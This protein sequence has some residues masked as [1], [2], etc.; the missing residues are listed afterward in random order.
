MALAQFRHAL[1]QFLVFSETAALG[2]GLTVQQHQALLAIKAHR[3]AG[4]MRVG[5]LATYLLLKPHS[6]AGLVNRL[7]RAGLVR[8]QVPASD[9]RRVQL[10]LTAKA[11]RLLLRLS[12]AHLRE[13]RQFAPQLARLLRQLADGRS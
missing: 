3:P 1:R 6:A 8:R 7:V 9:R 12:R 11:Q 4:G 13:L 10:R 5:E 2:M